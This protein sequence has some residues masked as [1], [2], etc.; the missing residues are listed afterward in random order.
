MLQ[1]GLLPGLVVVHWDFLGVECLFV[2]PT[3]GWR[4]DMV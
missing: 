1:M 3:S 2:V 4:D